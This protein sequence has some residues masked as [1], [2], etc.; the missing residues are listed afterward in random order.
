MHAAVFS[1][2]AVTKGSGTN[3]HDYRADRQLTDQ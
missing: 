2:A 1:A 3:F